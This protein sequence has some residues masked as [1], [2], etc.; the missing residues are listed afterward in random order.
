MS[1]PKDT[2]WLNGQRNKTNV[3][4]TH[5]RTKDTHRLKVRGWKKIIHAT[6]NQKKAAVA[7]LISEEIKTIIRNMEGHYIMIKGS[8]QEENKTVINIDAHY[9][10]A[11]QHIRRV[12]TTIKGEINI[13]IVGDFNTSVTPMDRTSGQKTNKET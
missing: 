10:G 2:D 7:I 3:Q 1:Q 9:I 6:G 8:I 12:L 5:F 4:E 13:I 11:P